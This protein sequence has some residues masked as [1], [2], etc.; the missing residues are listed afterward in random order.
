MLIATQ[1]LIPPQVLTA[2]RA[3]PC[4]NGTITLHAPVLKVDVRVLEDSLNLEATLVSSVGTSADSNAFHAFVTVDG[5][6][7]ILNLPPFGKISLTYPGL[8]SGTHFVRYGVFKG[9]TVLQ[10][11]SICP[12]VE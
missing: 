2:L 3:Q 7:V 11:E 4:S 12:R 5:Q 8:S 10:N 6:L 1:A 9:A